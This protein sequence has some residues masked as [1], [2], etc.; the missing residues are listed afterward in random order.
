MKIYKE[1]AKIALGT[2]MLSPTY[3]AL[4]VA[5]VNVFVAVA[6]AVCAVLVAQVCLDIKRRLD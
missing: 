2:V 6:V 3:W 1:M 5:G 4:V